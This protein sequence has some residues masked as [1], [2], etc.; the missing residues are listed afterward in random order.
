MAEGEKIRVL[1]VDDISET[2]ENIRKLLQFETDIEVV[3]AARSGK[4]AIQLVSETRPDVVLMDINMPDMDGITATEI[5]R[6]QTPYVQVVI[7]S[8]QGDQNYMRR[9]MLAGAREFLTKPPMPDE[10]TSTIRKAGQL[11]QDEKAKG[12]QVFASQTSI[13]SL[14]LSMVGSRRGKVIMV[15]SPKGGAGCTT[16]AV[17]L[18]LVLHNVETEA[19]IVDANLQF[20]DVAVFLNEQGKNSILDLTPRAEELDQD[21]VNEVMIK[22]SATGLHILSAPPK[23]EFAEKVKAEQVSKLLEFLKSMYAYIVVD[24]SSYVNDVTL[25]VLDVCDVIVLLT[26]QDIPSIKN[27][28]LFLDLMLTLDFPQDK[29]VF[30]INKFDKRIG[31][32]PEKIG[33][34]LKLQI[35]A[36]IPL[37]ERVVIPSVN[38]GVPFVIDNKA[39]PAA[40]GILSLAE[41]V[42]SKLIEPQGRLRETPGRR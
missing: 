41:A 10:L 31:I 29:V 6:K 9:A 36:V 28:R 34:N 13:A 38:R 42:R 40:K 22:N 11:A 18:A 16:V 3:G 30:S 19:A 8:V 33:E 21:I 20:G 25:A 26:T 23:P 24:T 15:Y 4:E 1:V 35:S 5:I 14:P 17:N 7:L 2:R 32:T 37:D 39:Q 27:I 12:A